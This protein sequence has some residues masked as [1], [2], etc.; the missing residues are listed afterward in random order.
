[1]KKIL[2]AVQ[3]P[4]PVHG[5]SLVNKT[6]VD[7]EK[8]KLKY[9]LDILEIQLANNME[10]LGG[11]SIRKII[12]AFNIFFKL[13]K[14]LFKNNYDLVYFTLSPLGFAFYKD[15]VLIFIIKLFK[16]KIVFHLHG[17]GI[18]DE[19]KS[20]FKKK[21]YQKVFKNTNVIQLA[22]VLYND[23]KDVYNEKP[24]ILPNG[25]INSKVVSLHNKRENKIPTFIYLSNLMKDKG[26]LIF[27]E[28][29]SKIQNKEKEFQVY[30]LGPSADITIEEIRC[31]IAKHDINNVEVVGSVY[32]EDKYVYLR[33]SDIFV[34]PTYY[35]NECFPL[36][37]LEAFQAGL[38]IISTD[39]GAI[40]DIVKDEVNGF[41][42]PMKEVDCLV[43]K[44]IY[45][46][47]NKEVLE[48]IKSANLLKFQEN[49]T[50][51]I[52]IDNFIKIMDCILINKE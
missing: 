40:P 46:M 41:I 23:I 28:A 45:L 25:I 6:L 4:P 19:L 43:N 2:F 21:I 35:R 52:F 37:I 48:T 7:N 5:A 14:K 17:K 11:F 20:S 27:L 16:K 34:L 1:M 8:I 22:E 15:V 50:E 12:N 29:I 13:F 30:I 38:A 26:V 32:G 3:L 44:M 39:N 49:Y 36:T 18:K 33:K 51:E 10:D 42:I 24:F 9:E 47:E 31:F